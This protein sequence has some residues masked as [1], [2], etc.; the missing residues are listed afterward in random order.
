[1]ENMIFNRL[2]S[3]EYGFC[4]QHSRVTHENNGNGDSVSGRENEKGVHLNR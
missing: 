3:F 1:M 2:R 4:T